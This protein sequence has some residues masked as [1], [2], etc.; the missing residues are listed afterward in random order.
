[1][2][3]K[4]DSDLCQ[5]ACKYEIIATYGRVGGGDCES[6]AVPAVVLKVADNMRQ[7]LEG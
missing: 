2:K 7:P 5:T 4:N 6:K 1:M 3:L